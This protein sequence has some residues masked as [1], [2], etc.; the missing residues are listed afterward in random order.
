M[1]VAAAIAAIE[2]ARTSGRLLAPLP[3]TVAPATVAQAVALQHALAASRGHLPPAGFKI[4]ATGGRM[5]AYLG[6]SEPAA[7]YMSAV[8][9]SEAVFT[10]AIRP[11]VECELAVR[12]SRDLPPAPCTRAQAED[13]VDA[14]AA[15][16]ELVENRTTDFTKIG[17]PTL[18]ADQFFHRAAVVGEPVTGWRALDL[19]ALHGTLRIDGADEDSG[20]GRDLLGHPI[21]CLAWLAGS[22]LTAAFGGLRAGQWIMLGSVIPVVWLDRPCDVEVDFPPLPPVRLRIA[23]LARPAVP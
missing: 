2:A 20:F 8:S 10:G 11:G 15:A 6:I 23:E 17:T 3:A 21:D 4:G 22:E 18:I 19:P 16:I 7:G 14:L 13:A 9:P 5:Q 12:L 1:K